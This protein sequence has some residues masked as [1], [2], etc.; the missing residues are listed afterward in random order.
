MSKKSRM[1]ITIDDELL[2]SVLK[3]SKD[4]ER[5]LSNQIVYLIRKGKELA[6]IQYSGQISKDRKEDL[7]V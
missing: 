6:D 7:S 2:E 1:T 3:M 5:S 4:C